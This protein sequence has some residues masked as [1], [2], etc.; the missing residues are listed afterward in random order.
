MSISCSFR[1]CPDWLPRSQ[2]IG[3]IWREVGHWNQWRHHYPWGCGLWLQKFDSYRTMLPFHEK[4]TDQDVSGISLGTS[5]HWGSHKTM[6]AFSFN[7]TRCWGCMWCYME[8]DS[9][10]AWGSSGLGNSNKFSYIISAQRHNPQYSQPIKHIEDSSSK[11]G[12]GTGKT[13]NTLPIFVDTRL[14]S[15]IDVCTRYCKL[16][17]DSLTYWSQTQERG[18]PNDRPNLLSGN[19]RI[20]TTRGNTRSLHSD[21]LPFYHIAPV[22]FSFIVMTFSERVSAGNSHCRSPIGQLATHN[23]HLNSDALHGIIC[24]W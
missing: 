17:N 3:K 21:R 15:N 7:R 16:S 20:Q 19:A 18:Q 8:Q 4:N 22:Q 1:Y 13:V 12:D 6:C 23:P 11:T 9:T 2:G 14:F 10:Y 5:P 24:S